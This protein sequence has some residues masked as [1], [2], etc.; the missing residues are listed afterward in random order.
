MTVKIL[1]ITKEIICG[2]L[3]ILCVLLC[4]YISSHDGSA[5]Y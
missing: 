2:T 4:N 1:V 3:W 5:Y